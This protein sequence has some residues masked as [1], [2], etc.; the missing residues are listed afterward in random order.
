MSRLRPVD[1]AEDYGFISRVDGDKKLIDHATQERFFKQIS[2][3][4]KLQDLAMLK[5][6]KGLVNPLL[7][8]KASS[9]VEQEMTN[10]LS[11]LRKLREGIVSSVR[12]DMFAIDVF[13]T[14]AGY[15]ILRGHKE[16][17]FPTM[18]YLVNNL[19]PTMTARNEIVRPETDMFHELLALHLCVQDNYSEAIELRHRLGTKR[20]SLVEPLVRALVSGNYIKWRHIRE[21]AA[22]LQ[23]R[24][25]DLTHNRVATQAFMSIRASYMS[26]TE[27]GL[28]T[29][30][31]DWTSMEEAKD[32]LVEDGK[33]I[34]KR[35]K[36]VRDR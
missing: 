6:R 27:E 4:Y 24:L 17:Y 32:L 19:Y 9:P 7:G 29:I 5:S 15:A 21:Q 1:P 3:R 36:A 12:Q 28:Y 23:Q 8:P 11:S 25:I 10:C 13:E 22:P 14:T 34:F 33:I 30:C 35:P 2:D 18:Q 16:T 20:T 31:G 26:I